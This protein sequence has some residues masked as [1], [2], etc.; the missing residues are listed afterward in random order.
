MA[1]CRSCH[2]PI[3]WAVTAAKRSIPID[4]DPD[5]DGNVEI[6]LA[7]DPSMAPLATVH[8]QPPIAPTGTMHRTHF[9]TCP[10]ADQHRTKGRR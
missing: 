6:T 2:A 5:D 4:L 8:A 9:E 3:F 10:H 1:S 7:P